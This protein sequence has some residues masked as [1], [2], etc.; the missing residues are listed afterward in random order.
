MHSVQNMRCL[1]DINICIDAVDKNRPTVSAF[2]NKLANKTKCLIVKKTMFLNGGIFLLLWE[3]IA[4][5][6]YH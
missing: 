1:L 5:N 4:E 2:K 3:K 6:F